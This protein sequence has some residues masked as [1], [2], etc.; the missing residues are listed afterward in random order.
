[1][2]KFNN[3]RAYHGS[4]AV[5][6]G[7]LRGATDKTDHF[8]FFCPNCPDDEIVRVLDYEVRAEEPVNP[9]D[10]Q[11]RSKAKRGFVLAFKIH[12]EKCGHADFV[13]LSNT[14]WQGGSHQDALG[15]A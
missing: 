13:K 9:Y 5:A 2:S 6:G 3:G 14:G 15:T 10:K 8:Y 12:C 4:N 11:C 1:M 7:G